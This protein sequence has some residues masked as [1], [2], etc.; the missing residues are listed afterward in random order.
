MDKLSGAIALGARV[1][2]ANQECM[3]LND[4][5]SHCL[6]ASMQD[7]ILIMHDK[8]L[9]F[10]CSASAF[11]QLRRAEPQLPIYGFWQL[12]RASRLL[13]ERHEL[14]VVYFGDKR[15]KFLYRRRDGDFC[16][17]GEVRDAK[18]LSG[19]GIKLPDFSAAKVFN[20]ADLSLRL[21][22]EPILTFAERDQSR[23]RQRK[24]HFVAAL[25]AVSFFSLAF[26]SLDGYL[27]GQRADKRAAYEEAQ[28]Q[29]DYLRRQQT[30]LASAAK[31]SWPW[32]WP[33]LKTIYRLAEVDEELDVWGID[34]SQN[35]FEASIRPTLALPERIT[36]DLDEVHY[37]QDGTVVVRWRRPS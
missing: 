9:F 29:V 7:S 24:R 6:P 21:P 12:M 1:R 37:R 8:R 5:V 26:L 30:A 19:N 34:L 25:I 23:Q 10:Y 35:L 33:A 11:H 14:I 15:G 16:L 18:P 31:E 2:L 32:Q 28:K 22:Q 27:A 36:R 17:S 20:L 3:L 4:V 13:E